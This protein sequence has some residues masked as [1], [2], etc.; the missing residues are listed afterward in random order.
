M[1]GVGQEL[2]PA[3][4]VL[5]AMVEDGLSPAAPIDWELATGKGGPVAAAIGA[6]GT[7][8]A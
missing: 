5:R 4:P 8:Y 3:L 1:G 2:G 7:I 6:A